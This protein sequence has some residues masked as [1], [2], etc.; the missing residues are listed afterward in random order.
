[1]VEILLIRVMEVVLLPNIGYAVITSAMFAF[2]LAGV[3]V[4]VWPLSDKADIP[5]R[6]TVISLLLA[7]SILLI[8]PALNGTIQVYSLTSVLLFRYVIA[9][10][11]VYLIL[12]VPFF[13]S[14]LL[15][16]YIFS[17][18]PGNIRTLYFWDLAGAAIGCVIF[19]PFLRHIGPGGLMFIAGGAALIAAALFT[20]KK[21]YISVAAAVA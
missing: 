11:L 4:T 3:Y 17:A 20:G 5:K 9:G 16:A 14:G 12:L 15:F 6:L 21:R 8:R 10:I 7:V 13:L 2:G 1:M 19:L 18:F